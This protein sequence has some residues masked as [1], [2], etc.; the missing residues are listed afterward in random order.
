VCGLLYPR[1]P[2]AR[3]LSSLRRGRSQLIGQF[4]YLAAPVGDGVLAAL[5]RTEARVWGNPCWNGKRRWR[6]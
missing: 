5:V 4:S 2:L 6:S 1:R 3:L